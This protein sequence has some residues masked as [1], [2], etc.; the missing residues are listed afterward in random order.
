MHSLDN[1][2][3]NY[4]ARASLAHDLNQIHR[5][6]VIPQQYQSFQPFLI[7]QPKDCTNCTA[8]MNLPVL[9]VIL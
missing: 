6:L 2:L 8:I 4:K 5:Q 1:S 9:S 7:N 3:F